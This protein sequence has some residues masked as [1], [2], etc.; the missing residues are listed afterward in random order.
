MLKKIKEAFRVRYFRQKTAFKATE[1][2]NKIRKGKLEGGRGE[3][4]PIFQ[5]KSSIII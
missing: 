1:S 3:F 4:A 2:K 5:S